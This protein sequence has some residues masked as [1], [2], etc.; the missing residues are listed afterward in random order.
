MNLF[1]LRPVLIVVLCV[2]ALS[3]ATQENAVRLHVPAVIHATP[4]VESNVYFMN[5]ALLLNRANYA[6]DVECAKGI[7]QSERW[8]FTPED[9]DVGSHAFT[10]VVRDSANRVVAEGTATIVVAARNAGHGR[11][12]SALLIGDSLTHNS[13]YSRRVLDLFA[14]PGNG[15]LQ[16]I[17]THAP[18]DG[19]AENRHEGYGGWTAKRF[20]THYVDVPASPSYRDRGSPF[21]Y[22]DDEGKATLDFARYCAEQNG[23]AAPDVVT[24]FLGCND[25][26]GANDESIESAIDDMLGHMD[27]LIEM[28]HGQSAKTAIG[29][30]L[31]V[32]PAATQDAFGANY[33]SGQTRWQ[34]RRNQH[35]VVE[36]MH[37]KYGDDG[38]VSIIPAYTNLDC[39]HNYPVART[40]WNAHALEETTRI[41]NGVHPAAE[42]YRQIGDSVYCWMKHELAARS[43]LGALSTVD[44][45]IQL[46]T[47]S[48]GFDKETCWVHPRAG[49]I[50]GESPAV[51]LTAQKLLLT[52]SDIFYALNEFR[53]DDLG[54]T[55]TGPQE[56]DTLSR[57]Q[58]AEGIVSVICDFTPM[59]HAQS[60]KL[61]G[62]GHVARYKGDKLAGDYAR[63]TAYSHYDA[64]TRTW[65]SWRTLDMPDDD[66]FYSS[67]AG[68]TQ[69]VDLPNGDILLPVYFKAKGVVTAASTVLRCQFDGETLSYVEH[70]TEMTTDV[71]RGFGEP[72]LAQFQGRYFLTLRNDQAGHV[73]SGDD[74]LHFMTPQEWTF[75]DGEKLESYNTQQHWVCHDDAL[76]LVFTRRDPQYDHVFRHRAPLRIAQVDPE[77][78]CILRATERILIPERG[79]RLGNFAVTKVNDN[80]TWV[81]VAEWMQPVG[82]EKYGSDNSIYVARIQWRP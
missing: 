32:P 41:T 25:T 7:Q 51:V 2:C 8:V 9:A 45:D 14:T 17:G 56:H 81:T 40:P 71:P 37:A 58:E 38:R 49:T 47:V 80:E 64:E 15:A 67:G 34:Y 48:S 28:V 74:G 61:L 21:L 33:K 18:R 35:R 52:G 63:Q 6:F 43:D 78:L 27:T 59:W 76:F 44:Y 82:C 31:P 60:G 42:G 50:P 30:I 20:A 77:R 22:A 26:F 72:S 66:K 19:E 75:D 55:W 70:G 13:V 53:T 79:A 10:L 12:V 29:L 73:T 11:R 69:R 3:A 24:I 16:L 23:G 5:V 57:R 4:G 1:S 39:E 46:D 62:T 36:R 65:A 68:S 54:K